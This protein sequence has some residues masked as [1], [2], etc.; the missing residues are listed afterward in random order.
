ME[1]LDKKV[2]IIVATAHA[3]LVSSLKTALAANTNIEMIIQVGKS[4]ESENKLNRLANNVILID[5]DTSPVEEMR[6]RALQSR[7]KVLAV[8]TSALLARAKMIE[9]NTVTDFIP[10]PSVL[11]ALTGNQYAS[12]I[13]RRIEGF[14]RQ[15]TLPGSRDL[16]K[17]VTGAGRERKIVAIASSTGG[18]NALE[19]ILARLPADVPPI[20][21]VQH[22]P[23]GFTKLFA[24][25]LNAKYKQ[26]ILEAQ[27]GDYLQQGRLLMAPADRHMK[28]VR[29]QGR[30]AV[31]CFLGKKM[32]GVMPA[33][34]VLF[35][36]VAEL[37]KNN[38]V[39]VV[40]T[41]MGADGARG[42]LQMHNAG[43]KNIGQDEK[44]CV[45]YGMPKVAKELGAIDFEVPLN[46]IADR[47]MML[48]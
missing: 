36:S 10:R 4:S 5:L 20:V 26:E 17:T 25:R 22:M 39:G 34:D 6:V 3:D 15:Q 9:K 45:V 1:M 2:R 14:F 31:E 47:I 40:L 37:A 46:S 33:A 43:C 12:A 11:T 48:V 38:A 32:H 19:D 41:G 28:L 18:T 16:H 35:E 29:Q 44:T 27:T 8:Y 13:Y 23:S 24:D 30:L 42:L 7:F 21:L